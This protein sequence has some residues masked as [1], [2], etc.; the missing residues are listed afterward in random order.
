[1]RHRQAA[2]STLVPS[3]VV[4]VLLSR[5]SYLAMPMMEAAA[6]PAWATPVEAP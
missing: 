2:A 4:T 6:A 3:D 1:M 5:H